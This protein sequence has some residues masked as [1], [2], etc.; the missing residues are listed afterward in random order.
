MNLATLIGSIHSFVGEDEMFSS[1]KM[2]LVIFGDLICL[3]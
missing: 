2:D 3:D 1:V